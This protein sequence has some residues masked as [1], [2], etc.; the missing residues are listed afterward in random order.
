MEAILSGGTVLRQRGLSRHGA[1]RRRCQLS[2]SSPTIPLGVRPTPPPRSGLTPR[3]QAP[4][5]RRP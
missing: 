5:G 3:S 4:V 1:Q 2:W